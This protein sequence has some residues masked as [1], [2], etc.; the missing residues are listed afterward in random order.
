MRTGIVEGQGYWWWW[1]V[2]VTAKDNRPNLFSMNQCNDVVFANWTLRNSP[3][4]HVHIYNANSFLYNLTIHVDVTDQ[5]TL[6]ASFGRTPLSTQLVTVIR[7]F[8]LPVIPRACLLCSTHVNHT[9][10][11]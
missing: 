9:Q 2:I 4:Y 11:C 3:M 5:A 8:L 7:H 1:Y 6:L 10:G